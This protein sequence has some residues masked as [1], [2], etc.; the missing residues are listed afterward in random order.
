MDI[1]FVQDTLSVG[2]TYWWSES[3]SFTGHCG[4]EISL[5]FTGIIAEIEEPIDD[6]GPLYTVQKG[7]ISVKKVFKV[8]ELGDNTYT[9]QKFITTD[10]FYGLDL[11]LGDKVLVF[12]YDYEDAYSI[13]G[14]KSIVKIDDFDTPI[15]Q[16][17]KT[18]I[19]S[20]QNPIPLKKDKGLW[21]AYGLDESLEQ[22]INCVEEMEVLE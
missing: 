20:D 1:E 4:N 13:P 22:I 6:A 9:G 2:Y 3:G 17:I 19:N 8:K 7:V 12:C 21:A 16:S 18:Y 10:C 15:I 14:G 5:A 11:K